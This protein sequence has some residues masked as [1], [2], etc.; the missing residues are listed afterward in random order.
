MVSKSGVKD[1]TTA[2][3]LE[4]AYFNPVY[5]RKTARRH[6]LNTDASFRF[7]RGVDP[8]NVIY[9]LKRAALLIKELAGGTISS[10]IVDVVADQSVM[11]YFPVTVSYRHINRLIGKEI[12]AETVKSILTALEIKILANTPDNLD[13]LVPPYR[14]DVRREADIIEEVLRCTATTMWNRTEP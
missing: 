4:S 12:P 14:V 9:A 11:E 10:D 13:L 6:G 5:I 7:E 8:N 1:S 3:F 2:I